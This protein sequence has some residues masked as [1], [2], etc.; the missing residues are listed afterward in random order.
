MS[1][2][3]YGKDDEYDKEKIAT[4]GVDSFIKQIL[5]H[6]FFHA[7]PHPG[8]IFVLDD[9]RLAFVDFGMVGHLND[10]LKGDIAK[11]FVFLSQRDA[12]LISKQLFYMG[13]VKDD[14]N[15]KEVEYEIIDI[16][17]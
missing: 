3:F 14:S 1:K 10:D 6:G 13:I 17:I 5:V 16:I 8:N 15:L 4:V 9:D 11:L 12:R 2:K 7:D